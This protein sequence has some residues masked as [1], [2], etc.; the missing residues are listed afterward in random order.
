MAT[1]DLFSFA[2]ATGLSFLFI[3]AA[4]ALLRAAAA[5]RAAAPAAV[6]EPGGPR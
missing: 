6:P 2:A 1:F 4:G 3:G 5:D